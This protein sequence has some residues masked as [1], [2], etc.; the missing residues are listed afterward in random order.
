MGILLS[1]LL[2][3]G[4][5]IETNPT[6]N[7]TSTQSEAAITMDCYKILLNDSVYFYKTFMFYMIPTVS[8]QKSS[9]KSNGV[10]YE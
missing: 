4:F 2:A 1:A 10:K 7:D 3:I 9:S 6:G 8:L 5:S